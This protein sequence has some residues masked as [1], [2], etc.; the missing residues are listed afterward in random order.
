MAR[1]RSTLLH[2]ALLCGGA[3]AVSR[4]VVPFDFGWRVF[5]G[6]PGATP[7]GA[8]NASSFP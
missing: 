4:E 7:P 8:C 1:T 3:M 2:V 5:L 6:K